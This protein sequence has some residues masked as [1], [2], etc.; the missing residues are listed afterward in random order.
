MTT[1]LKVTN[2]NVNN[3]KEFLPLVQA[4]ADGKTIEYKTYDRGWVKQD[5]P[6]FSHDPSCYRIKPEPRIV[7]VVLNKGGGV[8]MTFS[9]EAYAKGAVQ[10]NPDMT[11]KKF[12]EEM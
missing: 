1:S 9:N 6:A 5:A 12:V 4:L 8:H 11:Y 7:Y 3:A 10:R 2:M